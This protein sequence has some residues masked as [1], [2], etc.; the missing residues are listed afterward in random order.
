MPA[1]SARTLPGPG[2]TAGKT[3]LPA[4]QRRCCAACAAACLHWSPCP[5]L[6]ATASGEKGPVPLPLER[7]CFVHT[8]GQCCPCLPGATKRPPALLRPCR[9]AALSP[10]EVMLGADSPSKGLFALSFFYPSAVRKCLHELPRRPLAKPSLLVVMRMLAAGHR[11]SVFASAHLNP[12]ELC[13]LSKT[14]LGKRRG[15]QAV[16]WLLLWESGSW[17]CFPSACSIPTR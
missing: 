12:P 4:W 5:L 17:C 1:V 13:L 8:S 11:L 15:E 9:D 14:R 3:Q 10:S 16:P 2:P 7:S 6:S